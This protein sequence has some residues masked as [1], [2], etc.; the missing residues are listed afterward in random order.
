MMTPSHQI[1]QY[2]A[3]LMDLSLCMS[4]TGATPT[5]HR[6][7]AFQGHHF[8]PLTIDTAFV[9]MWALM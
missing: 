9:F 7:F 3:M 1:E 5:E 4:V 2:K 8:Y 6:I